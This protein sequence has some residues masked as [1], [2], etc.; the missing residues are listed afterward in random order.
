MNENELLEPTKR[1]KAENVVCMNCARS[2]TPG[3]M[4]MPGHDGEAC[5][6][7]NGRE[8]QRAEL[9]R[10]SNELCG[11]KTVL[12]C[13]I[14]ELEAYQINYEHATKIERSESQ[15]EIE[16]LRSVCGEAYQFAGAVGAPVRVLD[17]L[18]DAANG[19]KLRH[20]TMLPVSAA[21]ELV[22]LRAQ[23]Q[24]AEKDTKRLDLWPTNWDVGTDYETG[25]WMISLVTGS[26]NDREWTEIG[27]GG[28]LRDAIDSAMGTQEG[29]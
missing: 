17:N 20:E 4:Q 26:I 9:F 7:C 1:Y 25:E 19:G 18:S 8:A 15:A 12:G 16:R 6:S 28:S 11:L 27:R 10:V 14:A 13:R 21:S 22:A 24:E 5:E 29:E 2:P 3:W 23:L